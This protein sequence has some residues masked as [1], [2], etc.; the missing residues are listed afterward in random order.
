MGATPSTPSGN[1]ARARLLLA[2]GAAAGLLAVALGLLSPSPGLPPDAVARVNDSLIG[3]AEYERAMAAL[4]AD[5][6]SPLS[7]ADR[8]YVLDRLIDEELL[9]QHALDLE[10]PRHDRRVRGDLVAGVIESFVAGVDGEPTRAELEAFHREN[11]DYFTRPGR[12]RVG[13]ILVRAEPLRA[14]DTAQARAREATRRLRAGETFEQVKDELGDPE[15]APV[16]AG[17]LPASKLREYV[18]PGATEAALALEPGETSAPVRSPQGY[19]VV[20]LLDRQPDARPELDEIEVEVR[21]ELV[22]RAGDSALRGA[23]D[24][25]RRRAEIELADGPR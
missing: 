10:L 8:K 16:P 12:V 25:L 17:Y 18:G 1:A 19:H 11:L 2:L 20:L 5:R 14:A 21:A 24:E 13:H 4:A 23:L 22:R 7:R 3:A 9:V 15:I 6:R